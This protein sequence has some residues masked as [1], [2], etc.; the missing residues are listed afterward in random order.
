MM[1][2]NWLAV[3]PVLVKN[4]DAILGRDCTHGFAS[5]GTLVRIGANI[6][7]GLVDT[8]LIP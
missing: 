2:D 7:P 5:F 1:E 4:L 6:S 3:A 8:Q